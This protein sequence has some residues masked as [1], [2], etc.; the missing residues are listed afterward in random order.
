MRPSIRSSYSW[1]KTSGLLTSET[2]TSR[3]AIAEPS[4]NVL[5]FRGLS[6][7]SY[8]VQGFWRP[9]NHTGPQSVRKIFLEQSDWSVPRC[10]E[11]CWRA[12]LNYRVDTEQRI[13]SCD[14][15]SACVQNATCQL[16]LTIQQ[17]QVGNPFNLFL[18]LF[19]C[20]VAVLMVEH[21]PSD[22]VTSITFQP[23]QMNRFSP[24]PK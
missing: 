13:A 21:R 6:F 8:L 18:P 4:R 16:Q 11:R 19:F 20:F 5:V 17:G 22:Y 3:T 1:G 12:S 10:S 23:L 7:R 9:A 24:L 2:V 14:R 15:G